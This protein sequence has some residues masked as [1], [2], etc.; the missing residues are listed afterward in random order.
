MAKKIF[1]IILFLLCLQSA[2]AQTRYIR[3]DLPTV[4]YGNDLQVGPEASVDQYGRIQTVIGSGTNSLSV[5]PMSNSVGLNGFGSGGIQWVDTGGLTATGGTTKVVTTAS[6]STLRIGDIVVGKAGTAANLNA[7]SYVTDIVTNTSFTLATPLPTTPANADTFE[8]LRPV[9]IVGGTGT[10]GTF[11]YAPF[12]QLDYGYQNS[13]T[14]GILH[15]EDAASA[16]GDALVAMGG[17]VNDAYTSLAGEADYTTPAL[18]IRGSA[19]TLLS[20][21]MRSSS[22][23]SPVKPEDETFAD[24]AALMIAGAQREDALT[25]NTSASGEATQLKTD[26]SGRLIT[27]MA[28]MGET[29]QSCG[30]ATATTADVAI[31][32]SVASNR[33]YVTSFNCKNTSA[34]VGTSIDFK[35]G[36]TVMAVGGVSSLQAT[37]AGSFSQTFPVPLRGTSATALNFATNVSTSSVTCCAQGYISTQ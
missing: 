37:A 27:T 36:S 32:A 14:T 18:S 13:A 31:K 12:V 25:A 26:S 23:D 34:T 16:S 33:I 4:R 15:L 11:H 1:S 28:P 22:V 8:F 10:S 5:I 35:D 21:N 24:G 30:T 20:V 17:R 9:P 19:Y 7:W 29:F 3:N 2:E 6:T